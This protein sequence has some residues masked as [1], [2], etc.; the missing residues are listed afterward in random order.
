MLNGF[1]FLVKFY[2]GYHTNHNCYNVPNVIV[3]AI[4]VTL[5]PVYGFK[6]LCLMQPDTNGH[7][8]YL[9]LRKVNSMK[10]VRLIE[11]YLSKFLY[12]SLFIVYVIIALSCYRGVTLSKSFYRLEAATCSLVRRSFVT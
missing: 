7:T 12:G 5:L 2:I 3:L 9:S 1:I 6:R 4:E 8:S 11:I 10:V